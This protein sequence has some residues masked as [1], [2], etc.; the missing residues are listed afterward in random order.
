MTQE[1]PKRVLFVDDEPNVLAGLKRQLRSKYSIYTAE[2]GAEGLKQIQENGPFPVVVSDMR[3]PNMNG[4]EF[5]TKVKQLTPNTMRILLTGHTDIEAAMSAINEGEIFRFLLKPCPTESLIKTLDSAV[6]QNRLLRAE[7][8]LLE[9]TLQGSIKVLTD[10]L[11]LVN[12]L[13][14]SRSTKIRQYVKH[15]TSKLSINGKWQYELAAMLSQIGCVTVPE[16]ILS[17]VYA[18]QKLSDK[19]QAL[20]N[21]HAKIGHD[22]I[23][24]IPRL[25]TVAQMIQ[26]Q[27]DTPTDLL[28]KPATELPPDV[29]GGQILKIVLDLD[30]H[31]MA[32]QSITSAITG[33]NGQ[34]NY[35]HS[36][37]VELLSDLKEDKSE[38]TRKMISAAQLTTAMVIDEDIITTNGTLIVTKGQEVTE[39]MLARIKT[40]SENDALPELFRVIIK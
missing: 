6:D 40:F 22:L 27:Q 5:L 1:N 34:S 38:A 3:M 23:A 25:K 4:A 15:I 28:S 33:M 36:E 18:D 16:E 13:A 31:I 39:A 20:F 30:R 37:L 8:E 24:K 19:E 2:S 21:G 10:I 9:K 14:F 32:G 7:K 26:N 29:L 35:Y 12:P 17:K 11:S